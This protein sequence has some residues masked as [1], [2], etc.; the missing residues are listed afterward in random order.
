[1]AD[2]PKQVTYK[3]ARKAR[4]GGE[5]KIDFA[6]P[7]NTKGG[8]ASHV[9]EGYTS[10]DVIDK[11]NDTAATNAGKAAVVENPMKMGRP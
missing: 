8:F 5:I 11:R 2:D 10:K 7:E 1:M 6:E 9:P 4:G 3:M